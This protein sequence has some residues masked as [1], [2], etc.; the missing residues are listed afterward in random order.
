MTS[1]KLTHNFR[2]TVFREVTNGLFTFSFLSL[3]AVYELHVRSFLHFSRLLKPGIHP[4][5]SPSWGAPS[6]LRLA[7]LGLSVQK[8]IGEHERGFNVRTLSSSWLGGGSLWWTD[9]LWIRSSGEPS[10]ACFPQL[11]VLST[12]RAKPSSAA[13]LRLTLRCIPGFTLSPII[14]SICLFCH[15]CL[16]IFMS[17]NLSFY[18]PVDV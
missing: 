13:R 18:V 7:Q 16:D 4:S 6:R 5:V 12:L 3:L 2:K 11:G 10:C 17:E 8:Y 14:C 9:S 15:L 1:W